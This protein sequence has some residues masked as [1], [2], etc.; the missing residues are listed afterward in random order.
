M[1]GYKP[2]HCAFA[3]RVPAWQYCQAVSQ[4]LA[5]ASRLGE[6]WQGA[7]IRLSSSSPAHAVPA[8]NALRHKVAQQRGAVRRVR[9]PQ[10]QHDGAQGQAASQDA[11][12]VCQACADERHAVQAG[13][14]AQIWLVWHRLVRLPTVL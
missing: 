6:L 3:A 8:G 10:E 1:Q 9:V 13:A 11:V 2:T 12:Q 4:H 5:C 7:R 14:R